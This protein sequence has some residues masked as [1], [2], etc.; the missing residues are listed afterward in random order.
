MVCFGPVETEKLPDLAQEKDWS[1]LHFGFEVEAVEMPAVVERLGML[2]SSV[3]SKSNA[4]VFEESIGIAA[5]VVVGSTVFAS[6]LIERTANLDVGCNFDV[7]SCRQIHYQMG[8][9]VEEAASFAP[10]QQENTTY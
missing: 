8:I 4:A 5:A 3:E 1:R 7:H 2:H 6:A 9:L 10:D